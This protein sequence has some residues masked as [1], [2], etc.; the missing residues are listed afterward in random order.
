MSART[1]L[2]TIATIA[3][4]SLPM[5]T[6]TSAQ[7]AHAADTL[8]L[9]AQVAHLQA[10][11]AADDLKVETEKDKKPKKAPKDKK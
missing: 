4:L 3:L 7:Q 8:R 11:A 1:H 5:S 10:Q 6:L 9:L 2:A